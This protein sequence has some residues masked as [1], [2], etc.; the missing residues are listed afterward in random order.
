MAGA[1]HSFRDIACTD[2]LML[3]LDRFA[4]VIDVDRSSGLVR[5]QAGITIRELSCAPC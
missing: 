4:A 2:G 1:G 5:V 3:K